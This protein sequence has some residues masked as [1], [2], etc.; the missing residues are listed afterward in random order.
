MFVTGE[1]EFSMMT[2]RR[3]FGPRRLRQVKISLLLS[4]TAAFFAI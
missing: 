4:S 1:P 2:I 3:A